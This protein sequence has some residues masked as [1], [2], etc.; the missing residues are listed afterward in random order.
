MDKLSLDKMKNKGAATAA[1]TVAAAGVLIGGS[2]E[3]PA[4]ILKDNDSALAPPP[5]VETLN[6]EV[7]PGDGDPGEENPAA[8]EEEEEK[9]KGGLRQKTREVVMRLPL[10]V[11]A[12]VAVPLW[13]VGWALIS[14]FSL[15]WTGILSP[16]GAAIAKWVV[17]ALM[18]LA[19]LAITVKTVFPNT[20]LKKIFNKRSLLWVLGG[21]TLLCIADVVLQRFYPDMPRLF[22]LARAVASA[23]LLS[24]AVI[25]VLKHEKKARDKRRAEEEEARAREEAA[26]LAA[27]LEAAKETPEQAQ[28]RVERE[29]LELADSVSVR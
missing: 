24:A 29:I 12:C 6:A 15:L 21:S 1:A 4:D 3:A 16:V 10:A 22:D 11:R 18:I 7:D 27:A 8:D 17:I 28:K 20:P 14:I 13:C 19:A 9:K 23:A 25:P 2:F 26:A 5:I